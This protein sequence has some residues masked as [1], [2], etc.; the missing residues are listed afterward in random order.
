MKKVVFFILSTVVFMSI[1]S[2]QT[3]KAVA[4][5]IVGVVGDRIILYSDIKNA[6][7]DA[8]RQGSPVPEDAECQI[9]EQALVSK[10]LMLQAQKDSL[11]VTDEE[12]EAEL[13]Q[14]IRYFI[15]AYGTQEQLET[16]AGKTIYQIKDDARESVRENKLAQAMQRKIVESVRITPNE[17]KAFFDRIPTDSLPFFETEVEIGQIVVFPK[18]SRDLEKYVIDE[19]NN[20]KKQVEMKIASFEQ[21]A[22]QYS[23]EP[24]AKQSGGLLPEINRS[25]KSWD[26]AFMA[27]AFRLKD[28][29]ISP[30]VKSKFGYHIIQMVQRNGD[31]AI[32]RHIIR[33]P[34]VTDAEIAEGTAKLDS[35]RAKLIAGTLDFSTAAG[36]YSE[37]EAAKFAGPYI[38]SRSSGSTSL[39]IDELDKE[40]VAQLDKLKLGEYSQP[41]PFTDERGKKGVRIL[42]LKSRSE[43]HRMNIRDDY[44][45]IA[46]SALEE[47][48]MQVLDKWMSTRIST[49][50]IMV[51][52]TIANCAQLEK[53]KGAAKLASN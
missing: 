47:K 5:K 36:R 15:N 12:I 29:E 25:E 11:P 50:Y 34:P 23:E 35:V 4:D 10:L 22:K 42:Y 18:A 51:D 28:G 49:H 26:P 37:D 8:A 1:A 38:T 40:V 17:V 9:L 46:A 3:Q 16:V 14:R 30:V 19:M 53:W 31:R 33:I 43:P 39:A 52:P 24:G 41:V 6:I 21:L 2:A 44:S 7:A 27:A 32:V 45:K 20:Y 48:K 13:D